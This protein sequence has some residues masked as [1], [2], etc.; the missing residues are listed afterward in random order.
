[1]LN[2]NITRQFEFIQES[3]LNNRKFA[4]LYGTPTR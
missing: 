2:A 1:V 4:G 3:W